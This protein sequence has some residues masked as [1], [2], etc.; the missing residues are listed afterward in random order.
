VGKKNRRPIPAKLNPS[1]T[2]AISLHQAGRYPEAEALYRSVGAENPQARQLLGVLL[3]QTGRRE[4]GIAEI[5]AA[6]RLNPRHSEALGNLAVVYHEDGRF[7]VA[8]ALI[9]RALAEESASAHLLDK[10]GYILQDLGRHSEAVECFQRAV[11]IDAHHADAWLHFG[12]SLQVLGRHREAVDAYHSLLKLRP[13]DGMGW[14]NLGN[15]LFAIGDLEGAVRAQKRAIDAHP[16]AVAFH[17]LAVVLNESGATRKAIEAERTSLQIEPKNPARLTFLGSMYAGLGDSSNAIEAFRG[18]LQVDPA[19]RESRRRLAIA[20]NQ[21]GAYEE[22]LAEL[23]SAEDGP[24]LMVRA[25]LTPVIPT[26]SDEIGAS[27]DRVKREL[28]QLGET[29]FKVS[30]PELEVGMTGFYWAYHSES[31]LDLQGLSVRAYKNL[32]PELFWTSP[33]LGEGSG[34]RI[35]VGVASALLKRHT[36]GKLFGRLISSLSNEDVEVVLLDASLNP[37]DW[38]ERIA[39]NKHLRLPRDVEAARQIVGEERL[40]AIFYPEIGMDSFTYYLAFARLA[41]LQFTTW[42][43]PASTGLPHMDCF[44]SSKSLERGDTDAQYSER[45]VKF[46]SLMTDFERPAILDVSRADLGLP[47]DNTVYAC[48]Q[49]HFKLHPEFDSALAEILRRDA[50]ALVV[51]LQGAE[52]NWEAL[53]R[54]RWSRAMGGLSE[55]IHFLPKLDQ[56][57]YLGLCRTSDVVLDPFHFSGGNSSF[58]ALAMGAPIVTLPGN[59]LRANIT[60]ALY[61]SMEIDELIAADRE[62]YVRIAVRLGTDPDF[63]RAI[64]TRIETRVQVLFANPRPVNELREFLI[65]ECGKNKA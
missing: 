40:D 12:A 48:P 2:Q 54:M 22:A 42:G 60:S 57:E 53:L 49:T 33:H 21:R 11:E 25:I 30:R 38:T 47:E 3:C 31:E 8:L 14:T 28:V 7:A 26:S 52:A 64:R 17:N 18:A 16:S 50:N 41:P 34:A 13:M 39:S 62:D 63:R 24:G 43:H 56:E 5:E 10:K 6:V 19:N 61:Q 4:A 20:L 37:D 27:R 29:S 46:D 32:C 44:L 35:R 55:R 65:R 51:V 59:L 36:I 58:E 9:E 45:L 1:L 15:S 23:E